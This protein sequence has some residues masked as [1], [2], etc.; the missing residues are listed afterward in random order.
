MQELGGQVW[1]SEYGLSM[2]A[3]LIYVP[4][5][6]GKAMLHN[7]WTA[8]SLWTDSPGF[9]A[10]GYYM[11]MYVALSD[12]DHNTSALKIYPRT[13]HHYHHCDQLYDES[14]K[15]GWVEEDFKEIGYKTLF[16]SWSLPQRLSGEA[17]KAEKTDYGL[18]MCGA[19]HWYLNHW[20]TDNIRG[21]YPAKMNTGEHTLF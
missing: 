2:T 4:K 8:T 14:I 6:M 19:Y 3:H 17:H 13:H 10:E 7:D 20:D 12:A 18:G 5:G 16:R 1:G 15:K 9:K 11:N 21:V